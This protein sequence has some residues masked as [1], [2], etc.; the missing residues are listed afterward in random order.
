MLPNTSV[1]VST[2]LEYSEMIKSESI[3]P[4]LI[5][6][7]AQI[8]ADTL[9]FFDLLLPAEADSSNEERSNTI[10]DAMLGWRLYFMLV[11]V[12]FVVVLVLVL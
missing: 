12:S 11:S 7:L 5:V 2:Q 8:L 9:L 6:S 4:P 10:D 1:F 3:V